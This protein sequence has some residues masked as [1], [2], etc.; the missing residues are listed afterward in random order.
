MKKVSPWPATGQHLN[1]SRKKQQ[2]TWWSILSPHGRGKGAT[3][4]IPT[5]TQAGVDLN[6]VVSFGF[7]LFWCS[8]CFVFGGPGGGCGG[9]GGGF[10]LNSLSSGF[11]T[12]F[13]T[14]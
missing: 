10:P 5:L 4:E 11:A 3:S 2:T 14:N 7:V 1:A 13:T 8:F 12:T 9:P 6:G